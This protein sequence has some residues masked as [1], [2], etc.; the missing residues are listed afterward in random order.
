M[1]RLATYDLQV[2][3]CPRTVG[4]AG[5]VTPKERL[6][7][8]EQATHDSHGTAAACREAR[9]TA[10][11]RSARGVGARPPEPKGKG[12]R[13]ALTEPATVAQAGASGGETGC[14]AIGDLLRSRHFA[15]APS[16]ARA[17]DPQRWWLMPREGRIVLS[18]GRLPL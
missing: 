16:P 2:D 4:A 12:T 17:L 6:R 10:S 14:G 15:V 7:C 11:Q 3:K 18:G 5:G 13:R 8:T 1:V 9:L